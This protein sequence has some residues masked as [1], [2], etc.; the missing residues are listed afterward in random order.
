MHCRGFQFTFVMG[1]NCHHN[2]KTM[3]FNTGAFAFFA[4]VMLLAFWAS[5]KWAAL[6]NT[7]LVLGSGYFY[8][9]FRHA[10]PIYLA[11]VISLGYLGAHLVSRQSN[12]KSAKAVLAT[13]ITL[14]GAGLAYTKYSGLIFG[15]IPGLEQWQASALSIVAPIGIS[16]F[17]FSSIGYITDVYRGKTAAETNLLTYAA[18]ISYFPHILSGP[19]PSSAEILP[20]FKA[21]VRPDRAKIERSL[22]EIAWGLFKKMVVADNMYLT[23]NYC[24]Q[25]YTDLNGSSLFLGVTSFSLYLYA[26]FSGYSDIAM[27]VSRLMGIELTRNFKTPFFSRNPAE[28]WRRWHTSLRRWMLDYIYLPMGG[29]QNDKL[30]YILLILLIF[31]FSGLWHG[32]NYTFICWGLLNGLYFIPYILTGTL[33]RYRQPPSPGKLLPTG[34]EFFQMLL[35]FNLVTITRVFFRSPDIHVVRDFFATMCSRTLFEAP[36]LI[37]LRNMAWC[38]P[39][40]ALEWVQREQAWFMDYNRFVKWLKPVM[41]IAVIAAIALLYKKQNLSEYYYFKF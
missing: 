25:H 39:V 40:L 3:L 27:G 24:F 26:D 37:V 18:Y 9:C 2:R 34:K 14:I 38:I 17:T 28:F 29:N 19:I 4:C 8:Y 12:K 30:Q 21:P 6:R 10:L 41:H 7:V 35:T 32:A 15:N 20:Q 33:T 11:V 23:V 31:S 22:G 5:A 13:F 1:R 36:S 16:Y